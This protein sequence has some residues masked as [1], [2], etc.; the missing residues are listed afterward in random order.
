MIRR[1]YLPL[2]A[3]PNPDSYVTIFE[4]NHPRWISVI[5]STSLGRGR[6]ANEQIA[7]DKGD[8]TP[9]Q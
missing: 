7:H 8:N 1:G 5:L 4:S 2:A 6:L 9:L 3:N